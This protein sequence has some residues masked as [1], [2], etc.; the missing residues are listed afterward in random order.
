[1][2]LFNVRNREGFPVKIPLG[3]I[4]ESVAQQIF[5]RSQPTFSQAYST[6]YRFNT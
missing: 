1:M 5:P 6:I 3:R 2:A 4:R